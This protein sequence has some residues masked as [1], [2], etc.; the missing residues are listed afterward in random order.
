MKEGQRGGGIGG[1]ERGSRG[2]GECCAESKVQG[3]RRLAESEG[4]EEEGDELRP[5]S[6]ASWGW[7]GISTC[8][9]SMSTYSRRC[10][11]CV[12]CLAT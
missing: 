7:E 8:A 4:V 5:S 12:S 6:G 2:G 9:F 1:G 10:C 11:F 3:R